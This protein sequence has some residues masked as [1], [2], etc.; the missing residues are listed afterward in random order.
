MEVVIQQ[1]YGRAKS[2]DGSENAFMG[3]SICSRFFS[4]IAIETIAFWAMNNFNKTCFLIADDPQAFTFVVTR[5][6][7]YNDALTKAR[8]IG[9]EKQNS[10]AEVIRKSGY[11]N[12]E[13]WNWRSLEEKSE[14][15]F[16]KNNL[17]ECYE[18]SKSFRDDAHWQIKARNRSIIGEGKGNKIMPE[19]FGI[20]AKYVIEELSAMAYFLEYGKLNFNIQIFPLAMP[21]ALKG[22]YDRKYPT[23]IVLNESRSGYI[24]IAIK[25]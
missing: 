5:K 23:S 16:I 1:N 25:N 7:P 19:D 14:Y 12:I 20:A 21:P 9:I 22:L 2:L 18:K 10:I 6:M 3:V 4:K 8:A 11:Q 15:Q 13:I 24:Q 17:T